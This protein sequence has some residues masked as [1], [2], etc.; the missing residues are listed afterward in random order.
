MLSTAVKYA[1]KN[2]GVMYEP[3]SSCV[4]WLPGQDDAY[5]STIKDRSGNGNHGTITGATW[6]KL[7]SGLWVNSFNGVGDIITVTDSN[8]LDITGAITLMA[9]IHPTGWGGE[10][11]GRVFDKGHT[12]AYMLHIAE[13]NARLGAYIQ[14][15]VMVSNIN[16]ISLNMWQLITLTLNSAGTLCSFYVN[17]TAK[18]TAFPNKTPTANATNL[19]I[20]NR[21][22]DGARGFQGYQ[23][24]HRIFNK[25]YTNGE[26]ANIFN[27]ERHLFGV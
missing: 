1:R 15:V 14:N 24:M 27:Q 7:S 23:I 2:N 20:G 25:E 22:S 10:A 16:C 26:T 21:T 17:A 19:G 13:E 12:T 18:G 3:D 9:W 4:L 6:V 11:L 8:S 5:S